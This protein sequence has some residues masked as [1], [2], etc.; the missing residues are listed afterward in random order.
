VSEAAKSKSAA[1]A[2]IMLAVLAWGAILAIGAY[3]F[4]GNHPW[5]RAAVV[6]GVTVLFLALWRAA[7][8]MRQRRI[9]VQDET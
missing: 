5:L 6:F 2:W 4:G 7:L 3:L 1:T 9:D 8:A